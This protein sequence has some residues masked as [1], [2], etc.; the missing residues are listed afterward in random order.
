MK[1]RNSLQQKRSLLL[2]LATVA[3]IAAV[4]SWLFFATPS[5]PSVDQRVHDIASQLRCPVCQ[6]ESVA[7]APSGLA[8]QMRGIIRQQ[9]L[10]GK[11]D[12]EIIQYFS[13][14]Y[15]EGNIVWVPQWQG[16]TL[17]AWLVPIGLLLA[18]FL[19]LF[20]VVRDWRKDPGLAPAGLAR[21]QP[22]AGGANSASLSEEDAELERYRAQLEQELA[23]DDPLFSRSIKEAN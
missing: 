12:S 21:P 5:Q 2:L 6:G 10:A 23:S 3:L 11:S 1:A 7:D 4:W 9:V 22:A 16:F 8:L 14:R 19:F 15:G 18:G 13:S 17:L 20:L